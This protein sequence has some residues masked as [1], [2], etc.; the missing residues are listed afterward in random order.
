M[1]VLLLI[2]AVVSLTLFVVAFAAR[3]GRISSSQA[4]I[5]CGLLMSIAAGI[6]GVYRNAN[7]IGLSIMILLAMVLGGGFAFVFFR[8]V[9]R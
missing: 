3:S 4:G 7:S 5:A 1:A 2:S 8:P 9:K 6:Y